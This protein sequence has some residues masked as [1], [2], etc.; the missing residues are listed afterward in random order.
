MVQKHHFPHP[1]IL[2]QKFLYWRTGLTRLKS[3]GKW[4]SVRLTEGRKDVHEVCTHT[5][6]RH[7]HHSHIYTS[8]IHIHTHHIYHSCMYTL[9]THRDSWEIWKSFYNFSSFSVYR[10]VA[11]PGNSYTSALWPILLLSGRRRMLVFCIISFL[12]LVCLHVLLG[13]KL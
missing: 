2:P 6:T 9:H 7:I 5:H 10:V 1:G 13:L 8:H 3:T 12:L 11:C 4:S